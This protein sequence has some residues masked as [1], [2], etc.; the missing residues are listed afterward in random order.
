[1]SSLAQ[2]FLPRRALRSLCLA[3]LLPLGGCVVAIGND[4]DANRHERGQSLASVSD[5]W[6]SGARAG[7]WHAVASLYTEDGILLPPNAP[8]VVG[9]EAIEATLKKFPPIVELANT[10]A[11]CTVSGDWAF[12]RGRYSMK[13]KLPNGALLEDH[14]KYIEIRKR[15]DDGV[16]RIHRDIFNSDLPAGTP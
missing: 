16:W 7:D 13:L 4:V 6:Q 10:D 5:A 15:G 8:E 1:M 12:V 3:A 11:E 2:A 14:G 9:R